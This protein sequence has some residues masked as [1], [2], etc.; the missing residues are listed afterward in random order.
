MPA[1]V[2]GRAWPLTRQLPCGITLGSAL[3]VPSVE[4]PVGCT[5][6]LGLHYGDEAQGQGIEAR[7]SPARGQEVPRV[8]EGPCGQEQ[9]AA[10]SGAGMD[11]PGQTFH[12]QGV[13]E[14]IPTPLRPAAWVP[15]APRLGDLASAWLSARPRVCGSSPLARAAVTLWPEAATCP[16]ART[17][18]ATLGCTFTPCPSSGFTDR[19]KPGEQP[20]GLGGILPSS[21]PKVE[22]EDSAGPRE[23]PTGAMAAGWCPRRGRPRWGPRLS[24]LG[25]M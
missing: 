18:V 15:H 3:G 5:Q 24:S 21:K 9:S 17:E 19:K 6:L 7:T 23:K 10:S 14:A 4:S 13:A 2:L 8:M 1:S 11:P 25:V 20:R 12:P 22:P 16:Q